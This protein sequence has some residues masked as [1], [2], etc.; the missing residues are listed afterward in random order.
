MNST[1][2]QELIAMD[3]YLF[4]AFSTAAAI[5]GIPAN[6]CVL[7]SII[8]FRDM[9]TISNIYILNLA[10]ADLVFLSG[11]PVVL[12]QATQKNW[13]F[14][15][16]LCRVFFSVN[17]VTQ[18]ASS[19]FIA[20]LS[21]DRFLAVCRPLTSSSWRSTNTAILLSLLTWAMIILEMT[22]LL[23]FTKVVKYYEGTEVSQKCMLFFGKE[24]FDPLQAKNE[25]V[26]N[27]LANIIASSRFFITYCFTLSYLLPLVG[28]WCF[29]SGIIFTM[30]Q[31]RRSL[32]LK[33]KITK[34]KT[35]KVTLLGL[36]IAIS[37]TTCWLPF[38]FVQFSIVANADWI[39]NIKLL[40]IMSYAAFAL[41]YI[42]AAAN[43]FL[44]VFL[45]DAFR[46]HVIKALYVRHASVKCPA[47]IRSPSCSDTTKMLTAPIKEEE[48]SNHLLAP[49]N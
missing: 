19:A 49:T 8:Y 1:Q 33:R 10:I 30:W 42:N 48:L 43:P 44:Y 17:G 24:E 26:E 2:T 25:E 28:I 34:R 6:L 22:P 32:Y 13:M 21:F 3:Q 29:Y 46:R 40:K 35:T 39:E 11:T 23:I 36:A 7:I 12:Y 14:G 45:S 41:Q 47:K 15:S 20:V 31:R 4:H 18:F 9:R 16:L 5:F 27:Y 37:Y 38:W